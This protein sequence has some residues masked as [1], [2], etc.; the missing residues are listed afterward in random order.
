MKKLNKNS[1]GDVTKPLSF[2]FFQSGPVR[3]F[4]C[5]LSQ[6]ATAQGILLVREA[7]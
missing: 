6:V 5:Q 3:L 1:D 2:T 7:T 4:Y